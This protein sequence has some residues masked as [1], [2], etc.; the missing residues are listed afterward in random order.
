[1]HAERDWVDL[2]RILLISNANQHFYGFSAGQVLLC[3]SPVVCFI[4]TVVSHEVVSLSLFY[5][6]FETSVTK[7]VSIIHLEC[8]V[9]TLNLCVLSSF[10]TAAVNA[11]D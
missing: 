7:P 5:Q 10:R 11:V 3:I 8:G 1:M 2:G 9:H 4:L 6:D